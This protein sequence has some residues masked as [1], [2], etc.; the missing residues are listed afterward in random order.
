M[1]V[2]RPK[3]LAL[4]DMTNRLNYLSGTHIEIWVH[5]TTSVD[6]V[7]KP[8]EDAYHLVVESQ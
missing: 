7:A 6:N 1:T 2:V 8:V 5:Q 3:L 4:G